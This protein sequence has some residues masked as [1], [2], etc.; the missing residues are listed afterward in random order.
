MNDNNIYAV[1][2]KLNSET[3]FRI[4]VSAKSKSAAAAFVARKFVNA[5]I[6][7]PAEL[8]EIDRDEVMDADTGLPLGLAQGT[9]QDAAQQL[10]GADTAVGGT[11]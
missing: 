6:A 2:A 5:R 8:L 4:Y 10:A 7:K 11:D 3:G 9:I 1:D